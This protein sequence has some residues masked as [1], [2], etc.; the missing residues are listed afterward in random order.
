[1]YTFS[2]VCVTSGAAALVFSVFYILV[3][4]CFFKLPLT[5]LWTTILYFNA[6]EVLQLDSFLHCT[7]KDFVFLFGLSQVDIWGLRYLFLPLEWIGMNAMLVYVMAAAGIFAG[8]INGWYY[9]DPHNTLVRFFLCLKINQNHF[10]VVNYYLIDYTLRWKS[11]WKLLWVGL[12]NEHNGSI[13]WLSLEG[14]S[15]TH[16]GLLLGFSCPTNYLDNVMK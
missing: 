14:M 6:C 7:N 2:Y 16:V 13:K 11:K 8:F 3:L 10:S 12:V 5:G 15:L 9:E 1:M 4:I